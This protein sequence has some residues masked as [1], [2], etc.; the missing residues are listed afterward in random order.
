MQS[1]KN[2]L[3]MLERERDLPT[4]PPA[5]LVSS[6]D[7]HLF[8]FFPQILHMGN[9]ARLLRIARADTKLGDSADTCEDC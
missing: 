3:S 1:R 5:S 2:M 8:Y 9:S 4:L 6:V 7:E